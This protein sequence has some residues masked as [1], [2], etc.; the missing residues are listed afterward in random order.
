ME[1]GQVQF[2]EPIFQQMI[3]CLPQSVLLADK[4]GKI[5]YMNRQAE[6]IAGYP[7]SQL[8]G[9]PLTHIISGYTKE[10]IAH[11]FIQIKPTT[12]NLFIEHKDGTIQYMQVE[13]SLVPAT[14]YLLISLIPYD[15][16]EKVLL[17]LKE[18]EEKFKKAF[19]S[20]P[21]G[22]AITRG[23]DTTFVEANPAFLKMTGYTKEEIIGRSSVQIGMLMDTEARKK[24]IE[25]LK[26]HGSARHTEIEI[27]LQSA[28]PLH[29]L[30]S[31]ETIF[32]QGEPCYLTIHHDITER[33]HSEKALQQKTVELARINK[34]LQQFTYIA[35]H[36]L[37]EPLRTVS[38][39]IEIFRDDYGDL[40]KGEAHHCLESIS[41][42]N[43]RMSLLVRTL[44]D[45]S[46]L[47]VGKE[48]VQSSCAKIIQHVITDLDAMIQHS[49]TQIQV[50]DMPDLFIYE[51]EVHQLFQ[52]LITNAIKFQRAG[53]KPEIKI[54]AE[55]AGDKWKFS[56]SDNGIGIE[57]K[58]FER[59]FTIF[60][61][62][63]PSS[64]YEGSGIGLAN[65]KKIIELHQGEIWLESNPGKGTTFY[66]TL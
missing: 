57:P 58:Y 3:A 19:E 34:E 48:R 14:D 25:Q 47:G 28:P 29:V 24:I 27:N 16:T 15:I 1:T 8:I 39:Y 23:S 43:R 42:A 55:K 53:S 6:Q 32:L 18:S 30:T 20:S 36:D 21:A 54:Y 60:K 35:S 44:L 62:L 7:L 40:L 41:A 66:F 10:K 13:T 52:N 64:V 33:K 56:V 59:I 11:I 49:G 9:K 46:R 63:H 12:E 38:N 50:G 61:R 2:T 31:V 22:M 37:Q 51:T 5:A 26:Q 17:Q 45:Y 65:C 4:A